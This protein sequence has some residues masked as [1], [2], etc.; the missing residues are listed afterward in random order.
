MARLGAVDWPRLTT[1]AARSCCAASSTRR[2]ARSCGLRSPRRGVARPAHRSASLL[3]RRQRGQ[4]ILA[5]S[6]A[7]GRKTAWVICGGRRGDAVAARGA[8]DLPWEQHRR[9]GEGSSYEAAPWD[10]P[11]EPSI[12]VLPFENL[13][14][15]PEQAYF[16]DGITNDI[17]TD[18]SKFSTPVRDR[19]QLVVPL[20]GPR[21]RRCRTSRAISACATCSKAACSGP[22]ARSGSTPT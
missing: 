20:Q 16:A 13:S 14:G 8:L 22:T 1:R 4:T 19:L 21:G 12:A 18:L 10:L 7:S 17:I 5:E 3:A 11:A 2:R 15:D 6:E 9:A